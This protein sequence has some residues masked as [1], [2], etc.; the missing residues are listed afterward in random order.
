MTVSACPHRPP[1]DGCPRYGAHGIA[2]SAWD[3]LQSLAQAHAL[4]EVPGISGALSGFRH[5]ARLAIRGRIGSPKI[6]L[7][8]ADSHRIVHIPNCR[9]QHPLIN[10]VASIVR[11]ALVDARVSCYS[12]QAHLGVARYL[13]VA[14]ERRSQSAQVVLV[15]NTMD[16][17][18]LRELLELIRVRLGSRLHSLWVNFNTAPNNVILGT[19]FHHHCGPPATVEA[20]GGASVHYPPGAFGQSNLDVAQQIIDYLRERVPKGSR[21]T[22]FYAGVG[23]IGLSILEATSALRINEVAPQS[24]QG[25]QLGLAGLPAPLRERV[26]VVPGP[27]GAACQAAEDSAVV[28]VDPPRKG[29]DPQLLAHL[30]MQPPQRLLYVSCGLASLLHDAEQLTSGGRLTLTEI[31]AFNLMPFT[32]HVETVVTFQRA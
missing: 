25:L 20:F 22:E 24:L 14:V 18:P 9:V 15:A 13:Q 32:D 28:I 19:D 17:E 8:A 26:T 30:A 16:A 5:R 23:A 10:D 27:A 7:F 4:P 31:V 21:V 1:C 6:G 11:G 29:L 12:E 3:T 2:K